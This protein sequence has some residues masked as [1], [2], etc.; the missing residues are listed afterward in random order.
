MKDE[1]L[2]TAFLSNGNAEQ[3]IGR[4]VSHV[5]VSTVV[6]ELCDAGTGQF[7]V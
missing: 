3:P 4:H 6:H 1:Q 5:S 2:K 7:G